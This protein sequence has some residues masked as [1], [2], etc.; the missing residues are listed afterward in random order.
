MYYLRLRFVLKHNV[1]AQTLETPE[2]CNSVLPVEV[3][4]PSN[5][6]KNLFEIPIIFYVICISA[7]LLNDVDKNLILLAWLF[8]VGR[9]IHSLFHCFA[10]SVLLR[11][12]AYLASSIVIWL[13]LLKLIYNSVAVS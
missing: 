5:N 3:N 2:K 4:K 13:M 9:V 6:L 11:F 1:N 10:K 12:Y 8:V 7:Y